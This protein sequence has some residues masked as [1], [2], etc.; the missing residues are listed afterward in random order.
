MPRGG[1]RPHPKLHR[2]SYC[3]RRRPFFRR[4]P[5]KCTGRACSP[6]MGPATGS[7]WS[8]TRRSLYSTTGF[9]VVLHT[10][11]RNPVVDGTLQRPEMIMVHEP[12]AIHCATYFAESAQAP[13]A[14]SHYAAKKRPARFR[15]HSSAKRFLLVSYPVAEAMLDSSPFSKIDSGVGPR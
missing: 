9:K 13:S 11:S 2:D 14:G 5:I 3:L 4:C 8:G 7:E 15:L 1:G 12:H 10:P 6:E